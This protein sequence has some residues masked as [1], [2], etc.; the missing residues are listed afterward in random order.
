VPFCQ[1]HC[2]Y[3]N[4]TVLSGRDDLAAQYLVAIER[5]LAV[6]GVAR[7]IETLFLGGGTPTHLQPAE[8]EELLATVRRWF[9]L[10]AGY[11]FTVEANPADVSPQIVAILKRAGV[12][13][14]SLGAQSF[15]A[16]KLAR[17]ERDHKPD[18]IARA[19]ALAREA[20]M[21]ASLDLIFAA[22]GESLAG[23]RD[24]LAQAIA[25]RPEHVSTYGLTFE[26]GT[27]FWGRLARGELVRADEET[28]RAMYEMAIDTLV[29]AGFEHYEVSNFDQ[30]AHRCRHNEVYWSGEEYFAAGPGAARYID[31]RR[32][33]NHRSTTTWLRRVLAGQSPVAEQETLSP[34][35]RARE[36][37]VLGLRRLAGVRRAEFAARTGYEVDAL[38]GDVLAGFVARGLL[39][40]DG[41]SVRLTRE[42]L[43]V[44]DALWPKF[45]RR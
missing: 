16:E 10:A 26:R 34:E 35:D 39:A 20:G 22:P 4:F 15:A 23:W 13:R 43:L 1:H 27:T 7:P 42:G 14:L 37:L 5:E 25:L 36:S 3:C 21:S 2:G 9:A 17:L 8:L 41:R 24:D 18:D 38:V 32:E 33:T 12:T 11:E 6:L 31:G 40:D 19:V 45:L 28:E 44:S 29:M 30:P